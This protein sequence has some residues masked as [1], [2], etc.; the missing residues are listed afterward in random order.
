MDDD[1]RPPRQSL[2]I[3]SY[4]KIHLVVTPFA[5]G[6]GL[7]RAGSQ[8]HYA[9][10]RSEDVEHRVTRIPSQQC[11]HTWSPLPTWIK[12]TDVS[13][14]VLQP[15]SVDKCDRTQLTYHRTLIITEVCMPIRPICIIR[16]KAYH[17]AIIN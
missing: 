6:P 15:S 5:T 10:P 7:V 17:I 8:P 4:V 16:I 9:S 2:S 3:I 11:E 14:R 13:N 12:P 1:G